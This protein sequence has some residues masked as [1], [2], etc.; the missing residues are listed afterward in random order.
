MKELSELLQEA[1]NLFYAEIEPSLKESITN[2]LEHIM[3]NAET[4]WDDELQEEQIF[5]ENEGFKKATDEKV[6]LDERTDMLLAE[7]I[8]VEGCPRNNIQKYYA[9]RKYSNK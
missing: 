1:Y 4:E 5:W 9:R 2:R 6:L 8:C 7:D 3:H